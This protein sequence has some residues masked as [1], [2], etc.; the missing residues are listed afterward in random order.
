MLGRGYPEQNCSIARALEAFGDRWSLL[1]LRDAL[2][3]GMTRYSE[4]Q[5]SLH[6]ASN[7]LS[8]R[9]T[10]FVDDGLLVITESGSYQ[11]TAKARETIPVLLALTAWGDIWAAPQGAPVIYRNPA[12]AELHLELRDAHHRVQG[13][14][15]P[16]TA[17]PGPGARAN[18][19]TSRR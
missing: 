6:L 11:P 8:D 4:F 2:F 17:H 13:A 12:G 10:R 16:I 7:V 3:R 9:L 1:I 19:T 18:A 14:S 5:Q 15:V